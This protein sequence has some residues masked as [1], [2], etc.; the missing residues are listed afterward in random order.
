VFS[1]CGM[2][3]ISIEYIFKYIS[4][5][6]YISMVIMPVKMV[7]SHVMYAAS[8]TVPQSTCPPVLTY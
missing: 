3:C 1:N 4:A 5:S 8:L 7:A 2:P 6:T